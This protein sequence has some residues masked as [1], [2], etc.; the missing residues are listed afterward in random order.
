ME[1]VAGASIEER[2]YGQPRWVHVANLHV[3]LRFLGATPDERQ[4]EIAAVLA[5]LAA[6]AGAFR[7]TIG[8]AGAFPSMQRPRVLWVGIS[9]G[10]E[11]LAALAQSV[12]DA[13]AAHGWQRDERPLQA[14]LTVA[15]TDG[16]PGA[17]EKASRLV[18]LARDLE[19]SW[20]ADRVI[21]YK[22]VLGHGPSH[23]QIV[24]ESP[25]G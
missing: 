19:L 24:A 5:D 12:N 8:G 1:S 21:L 18:E 23:Y 7:V 22:S 10:A 25:L 11:E 16:V 20:V 9:E 3:T 15:R 6:N 17:D 2:A 4:P 14:H 13:L